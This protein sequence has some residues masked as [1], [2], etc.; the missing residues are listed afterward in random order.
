MYEVNLLVFPATEFSSL[1]GLGRWNREH[2]WL[3]PKSGA[4]LMKRLRTLQ[5]PSPPD[6]GAVKDKLRRRHGYSDD[7][8][9]VFCELC[10]LVH[11]AGMEGTTLEMIKVSGG[12]SRSV[13]T[14]HWT[15]DQLMW[16]GVRV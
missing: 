6:M 3:H 16:G 5:P 2:L 10:S 12:G 1:R 4:V 13:V 8:I 14:L 9:S 7:D 11:D 15:A